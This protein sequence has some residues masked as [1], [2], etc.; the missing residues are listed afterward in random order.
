MAVRPST[1]PRITRGDVGHSVAHRDSRPLLPLV[2]T[3][4]PLDEIM[5]RAI[6]TFI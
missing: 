2:L 4:I 1:Y 6:R 3:M 5:N